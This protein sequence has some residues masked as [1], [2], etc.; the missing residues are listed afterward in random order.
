[1]EITRSGILRE[2]LEEKNRE[3]HRYSKHEAGLEPLPGYEKHFEDLR[4][5]CQLLRGMILNAE[6]RERESKAQAE[7]AGWQMDIIKGIAPGVDW[8][9]KVPQ[10]T[11]DEVLL[12]RR[13]RKAEGYKP[14]P[15]VYPGGEGNGPLE[16]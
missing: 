15:V 9:D 7:L 5:T 16:D 14:A 6:E 11:M 3:M 4:Q 13:Y 1:M 12:R 2:C 10:Q 8:A